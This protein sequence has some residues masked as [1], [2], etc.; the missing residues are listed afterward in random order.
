M[1]RQPTPTF[2]RGPHEIRR[3][4]DVEQGAGPDS[5]GSLLDAR[6]PTTKGQP[7]GL[8]HRLTHRVGLE[9]ASGGLTFSSITGGHLGADHA[10]PRPTCSPPPSTSAPTSRPSLAHRERTLDQRDE[11][12]FEP[13]DG[14]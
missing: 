14:D 12:R 3:L 6:Q 8:P 10:P 2:H 1:C 11:A 4:I 9:V 7:H 5:A 13:E